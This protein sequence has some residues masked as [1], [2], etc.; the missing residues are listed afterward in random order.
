MF[1]LRLIR[2]DV[3][4]LRRR[5]GMLALCVVM[6]FGVVA[7]MVVV[8]ALQHGGNPL[9][10]GPAGGLMAYRDVM[11]AQTL[12]ML[13]VG[14]IVGAT[15]GAQDLES[16]VFRDLAATGR[17]RSALFAARIPGACAIVLAIGTLS[18]AAAAIAAFALADGAITPDAA[19][20]VSA[21]AGMLSSGVLTAAVAVGLSALTGSKSPVIATMLA[22]N[23]AVA[24]LLSG[25]AWLGD[26]RQAI[27]TN[28]VFRIGEG[29]QIIGMGLVTA[30]VVVLAWT[31]AAWAAGAWRTRTR[32]L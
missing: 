22:F 18:S 4:K 9:D 21:T 27:P 32:E 16:G 10:H 28:A 25:I 5:R 31:A 12:L 17:S 24:P 14:T 23:L 19:A 13:V 15:A 26:V 1:D 2:A 6:T 8:A 30:I 3:L 11:F 29:P 7:L 20:L